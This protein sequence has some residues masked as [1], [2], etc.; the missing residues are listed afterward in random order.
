MI[1]PPPRTTRTDTLFPYTTLFRSAEVGGVDILFNCA[2]FVHA[3]TILTTEEPDFDFS[4][5]LNVKSAYRMIRAFLP[6]MIARGGG[7]IVNMASVAGSIIGVNNRFVY[8]ASKAAVI[9]L[10]KSVAQ[11]FVTQGIRCHAIC[12]EIGRASCRARV[13]PDVSISVVAVS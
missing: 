8:G 9:G 12:P 2:G 11:D 4:F 6:A 5:D 1:R 13:C 10:T 3:G 7:S